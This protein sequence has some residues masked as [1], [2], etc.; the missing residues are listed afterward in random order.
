M[1]RVLIIGSG[2]AGK[3]TFAR[4]LGQRLQLEVIHLDAHYWKSGWVEPSKDEWRQTVETLL[5]QEAWVMDGNY[6]GTLDLR[7]T[8]ADAVIFLDMP[9]LMCL[10]RI[11]KRRLQYASQTRPDMAEG[12]P[13]QLNWDFMRYV[14]SYPKRRRFAIL[15][16]LHKQ[17]NHQTVIVLRSPAQ[18]RDFLRSIQPCASSSGNVLL[19]DR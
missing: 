9:R 8:V 7:L 16:T 4:E 2:G 1:Q 10:W 3:S 17:P 13:E 5:Q 15:E 11:F 18:V 14:W 19:C 12:C 6:S